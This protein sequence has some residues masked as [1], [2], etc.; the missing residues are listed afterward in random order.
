MM[1]NRT[2]WDVICFHFFWSTD[3]FFRTQH[4]CV[5]KFGPVRPQVDA[6]WLKYSILSTS[7]VASQE[8]EK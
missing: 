5:D 8:E 6:D 7:Q 4:L 3:P 1:T 2:K